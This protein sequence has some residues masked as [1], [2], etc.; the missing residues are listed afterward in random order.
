M[1]TNLYLTPAQ[2]RLFLLDRTA[3]DNFLL[4]DVD[5]TD[6]MIDLA[7]T[8][9]VDTYNTTDPFIDVVYDVRTFPFRVELLLG[10]TAYLLRSKGLNMKRNQLNYTS[11]A[12]TAVDDKRTSDDYL[13]LAEKYNAE[14]MQRIR[15]IKMHINVES[16]YGS[17]ESE[18][19]A[20]GGGL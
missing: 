20:S 13:L 1:A 9:T 6:E 3:G 14:F 10:V 19:S 17:L 15:K 11:A 8:L 16:G 18:Y 7:L 5:F 12:G 4:D 2:I